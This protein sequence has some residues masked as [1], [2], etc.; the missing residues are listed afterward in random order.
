MFTILLCGHW[1]QIKDRAWQGLRIVGFRSAGDISGWTHYRKIGGEKYCCG[2]R[3]CKLFNGHKLIEF[4]RRMSRPSG[5]AGSRNSI[6]LREFLIHNYPRCLLAL[7]CKQEVEWVRKSWR[8]GVWPMSHSMSLH[9]IVLFIFIHSHS[10][11]FVLS[12]ILVLCTFSGLRFLHS[13]SFPSASHSTLQSS[14]MS[15]ALA[16]DCSIS[17]L[18]VIV[19]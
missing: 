12:F 14:F 1:G 18:S 5:I 17:L 4:R 8:F 2:E 16:L 11:P 7:D 10:V 19:M 15:C 13:V 9:S 6:S 3:W